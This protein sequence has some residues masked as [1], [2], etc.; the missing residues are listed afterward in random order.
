M[1]NLYN[2]LDK[3][4]ENDTYIIES[5][6]SYDK[7]LDNIDDELYDL[8]DELEMLDSELDKDDYEEVLG[9]IEDLKSRREE[10]KAKQDE[11]YKDLI[12]TLPKETSKTD[13]PGFDIT[14]TDPP[15]WSQFIP[16]NKDRD[17]MMNKE[18]Y[19]Y[20]YIAE[21]TP[22]QYLELCSLYGWGEER[23]YSLDSIRRGLVRDDDYIGKMAD[24]MKSGT[25]FK[26]PFVDIKKHGQEGRHRAL[27]AIEAGIET[28]PCLILA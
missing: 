25:K 23:E 16:G 3:L 19:D 22:E 11:E 4:I 2:R 13:F 12:P 24:A 10:I 17:Y 8:Q 20:A 26:L 7:D 1:K 15:Y 14:E 28:I 9:K 6:R 5:F 21:L 18:G 27:A